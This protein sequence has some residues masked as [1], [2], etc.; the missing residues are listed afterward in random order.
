[1]C[2]YR[3][4]VPISRYDLFILLLVYVT[5]FINLCPSS[6]VSKQFEVFLV[7]HNILS[8]VSP[9]VFGIILLSKHG[10]FVMFFTTQL[11]CLDV[12]QLDFSMK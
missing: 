4:V 9:E 3:L 7:S 2:L 12:C 6:Y 10:L 8:V 1:M 5:F 11:I